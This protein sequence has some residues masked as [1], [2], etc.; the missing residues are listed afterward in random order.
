MGGL[1]E[2]KKRAIRPVKWRTPGMTKKAQ[3]RKENDGYKLEKVNGTGE[4]G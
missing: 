4:I 3:K 2:F 1:S